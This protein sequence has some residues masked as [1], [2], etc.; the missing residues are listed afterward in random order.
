MLLSYFTSPC[1]LTKTFM[2]IVYNVVHGSEALGGQHSPSR[3]GQTLI[4]LSK[5]SIDC[6]I[7][8]RILHHKLYFFH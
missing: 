6:I 8:Y 4:P 3:A 2:H 1:L 5:E 7:V